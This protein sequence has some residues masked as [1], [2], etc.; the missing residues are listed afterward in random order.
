MLVFQLDN[1]NRDFILSPFVKWSSRHYNQTRWFEDGYSI[2]LKRF[3]TAVAVC[4]CQLVG[5]KVILND[6]W[7]LTLKS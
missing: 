6:S 4:D 5:N 2:N 3:T 1:I 7:S